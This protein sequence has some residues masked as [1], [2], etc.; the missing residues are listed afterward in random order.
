MVRPASDRIGRALDLLGDQWVLLILQ[1]AFRR[2]RRFNDFRDALGI[3]EAVLAA[4]LRTLVEAGV[5]YR[6]PYR[7]ARRT[8]DEYRL[9]DA[10]LELWQVLV[11]I[12]AWETRW[13]PGRA[14]ELPVLVHDLCDEVCLP[15]LVCRRCDEEVTARDTETSRDPARQ[16]AD[17]TP[18]RRFRRSGWESVADRPELFYP[19]TM[20]ILGDRWSTAVTAAAFLGVRRFRDLETELAIQPS[21]LSQRLADLVDHGVL[22]RRQEQG[23]RAVDY[24]LTA[25]GLD[26]FPVFALVIAWADRWFDDAPRSLEIRHRSCGQPLRPALACDRCRVRLA[27]SQVH[28]ATRDE[29]RSPAGSPPPPDPRPSPTPR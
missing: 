8:R 17:A 11:A 25:K 29:P 28:F 24:G 7:D 10:G 1:L 16:V 26:F 20:T 6:R 9:T 13:V 18:P 23:R 21:V 5:L 12:W 2:V 15:V 27:R 14:T 19:E 22:D 3:S 4:R